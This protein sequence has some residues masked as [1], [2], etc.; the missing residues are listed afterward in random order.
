MFIF[1]FFVHFFF[2]W[3]FAKFTYIFIMYVYPSFLLQLSVALEVKTLHRRRRVCAR[4]SVRSLMRSREKSVEFMA[5]KGI[6]FFFFL[7]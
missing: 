7:D 5:H 4:Q 6:F 2:Y 1:S 3:E